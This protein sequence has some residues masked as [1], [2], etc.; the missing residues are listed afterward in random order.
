MTIWIDELF[1]LEEYRSKGLGR[2]LIKNYE[3]NGEKKLSR[4][5]LEVGYGGAFCRNFPHYS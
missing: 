2:E 1:V 5:R 3:E 4:N